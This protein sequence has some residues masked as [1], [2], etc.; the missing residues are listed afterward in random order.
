MPC[1][2]HPSRCDGP[3]PIALFGPF[4]RPSALA[5]LLLAAAGL[6]PAAA[7][8]QAAGATAALP[9]AEVRNVSET[10]FGTRVDDPYRHFENTKDPQVAAW[11]KAHSD[12]A[13]ATL[14]SIAGR[15][16]LRDRLARL[17]AS[18]PARVF[19][20][21]RLPGDRLF[22]QRRAVGDDQFKLF[23]R[24]GEQGAER[25]LFDPEALHRQTGKPHAL[26]YF[27]PSPDGRLVGLGVS[28][29]GSEDASLR[30]LDVATGRQVGPT[31]PR[32]WFGSLSWSP[33]SRTL[34]F[35]RVQALKAGMEPTEQYLRSEA[36]SLEPRRGWASYRV[37]VKAGAAGA[38]K[39]G[40]AE[41]PFLDVQPDGR[42]LLMATDGVS[43]EFAA[44]HTTLQALRAGRPA[45]RQ[46]F[47]QDEAV[48]AVAV[49]GGRVFALTHKAAPRYRII[50]GPLE[51][52]S[53]AAAREVIPQSERVITGLAAAA[54]AVYVEIREGNV[55]RLQRLDWSG[56]AA[57]VEIALPVAGSFS[58][59]GAA[60][61][62]VPG[63]TL[64]LRSWT[65]LRQI[66]RVGPDGTVANTGLQARAIYDTPIEVQATEV[67]VTSHDG[68]RVPMSIIHR[69]GLA[70]DGSHPAWLQGY[71]SYGV[72]EEP[73]F[74]LVD[75]VWMEAGGIIAVANPR[76]S[77]VFGRQWHEDGKQARKPNTWRDFIAC[78]EY[79]VAQGW[80]RPS[81]LAIEGGSAGGILI[82]RAM[83]ERPDLFAVAMP[84]V[85]VLDVLRFETTPNG[86]PNIPE[87]GSRKT[88]A[89]FRALLEMSTYHQ[90][91][92]GVNYPAVLLTHGVNDP[93]VE[94]WNSTKT[95]AR[96]MAASASG[97]P[98]LLRLDYQAGHGVG[99]T[100]TQLLEE[101][102][103][104]FAFAL[105]QM[106]V[107][108][109][110]Q[111][112]KP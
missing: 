8:P 108:G 86:V 79:L 44:W 112:A 35:H 25:L 46:L 15:D 19:G 94:V 48:T 33:D 2:V 105:W 3:A 61:P 64:D 70:L 96:L 17:D 9:R 30:V 71:G 78:A 82:G 103:D 23:V 1:Q 50:S 77:G 76:G 54:D 13:I 63:V 24:D 95:A 20:V 102:A 57:P 99:S 11:M 28:A 109:F 36:V 55:K 91:R 29:A 47:G 31:V 52:F 111:R 75:L 26:N 45:W 4:V 73:V 72:T 51:G 92:D 49:K 110:E 38:L 65:Q 39:I 53:V 58:L 21:V 83:T 84:A 12:H 27:A 7:W 22:Y 16:A 107:P 37:H 100:R 59:S 68:A 104:L 85:G 66:Y 74:S 5:G 98:V 32:A 34:F 90:I 88:E 42:V 106:G 18:V 41:M 56:E 97:R 43:S 93:R 81:R 89:G 80:T 69:K 101:R 62:D 67:M 10:F 40:P 87:F 14:R 6:W 60:R